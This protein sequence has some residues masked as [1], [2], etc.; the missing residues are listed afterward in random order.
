MKVREMDVILIL[1]KDFLEL[2]V[3]NTFPQKILRL[4]L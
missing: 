2:L 1:Y 3:K 4:M